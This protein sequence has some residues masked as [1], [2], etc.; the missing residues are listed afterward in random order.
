MYNAS[1]IAVTKTCLA[2]IVNYD[3]YSGHQQFSQCRE[4][5]SGG[6][7]I[8]FF[9]PYYS[10]LNVPQPLPSPDSCNLLP[11]VDVTSGG[12][13]MLVHR[14]PEIHLPVTCAYSLHRLTK[15]YLRMLMHLYWMILIC[16]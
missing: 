5:G 1:I 9:D 7:V 12:Y 3:A 8:I 10:V 13:W 6:G 4:G 16:T 14:P 2:D 15:L 11:V